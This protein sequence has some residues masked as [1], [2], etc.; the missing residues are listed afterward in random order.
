MLTANR[1]THIETQVAMSSSLSIQSCGAWLCPT[2]AAVGDIELALTSD[3]PNGLSSSNNR[4][5]GGDMIGTSVRSQHFR[6][7]GAH[8]NA[9]EHGDVLRD[10]LCGI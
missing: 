9:F 5:R 10:R 1:G 2:S 6:C 4:G 8:I 7:L 3:S